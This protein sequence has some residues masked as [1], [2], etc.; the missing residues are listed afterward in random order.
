MDATPAYF[1]AVSL[2][3]SR[4]LDEI[5]LNTLTVKRRRDTYLYIERLGDT[6]DNLNGKGHISIF[7]FGSQTEGTTTPGLDSDI[8]TLICYEDF[9]VIESWAQWQPNKVNYLM[10]QDDTSPG[11]C[12]LQALRPDVPMAREDPP[13]DRWAYD[14]TGRVIW[15]NTSLFR[16]EPNFSHVRNGPAR[17]AGG[18]FFGCDKDFVQALRCRIW[19]GQ[20]G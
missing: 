1:P 2:H 18:G 8:D 10:L 9:N 4:T 14:S 11:Y 20:A 7:H 17:S 15:P 16:P 3:L 13:D 5:G 12:R 19:P 6:F